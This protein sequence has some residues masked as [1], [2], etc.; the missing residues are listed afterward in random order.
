MESNTVE[1]PEKLGQGV[2]SEIQFPINEDYVAV[3]MAVAQLT[4]EGWQFMGIT[5]HGSE[6]NKKI[7]LTRKWE[8]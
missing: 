5:F 8:A 1:V 4:K 7:V 3:G 2:F 6:E